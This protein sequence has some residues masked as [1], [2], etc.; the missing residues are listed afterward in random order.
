[1]EIKKSSTP[2]FH[3]VKKAFFVLIFFLS[4]LSALFFVDLKTRIKFIEIKNETN[5]EK[6][7]GLSDYQN[8]SLFLINDK[9]LIDELKKKNPYVETVKIQKK[10]PSSLIIYPNFYQPVAVL[11]VSAGYFVLS[12]DGRILAKTKNGVQ[13]LTAINY[14]QKLNYYF[15]SAGDYLDLMDIKLGLLFSQNLDRLGL[16]VDILDI[17]DRDMLVCNVGE[18]KI[19]FTSAKDSGLQI[20]EL[21]QIIRQFKIKG[22]DFESIDLRFQ[23]PVVKL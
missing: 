5:Q 10:F 6:L 3:K 11:E 16:R 23:K 18:K 13:D 9:E 14:Y 19:I 15:Y 20:Y 7:N 21:N 12:S 8:K 1:M 4:A 17:A 22:E 2:F